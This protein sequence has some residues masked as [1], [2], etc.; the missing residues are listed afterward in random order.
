MGRILTMKAVFLIAASLLVV[1]YA[2]QPTADDV[3]P[4]AQLLAAKAQHHGHT[5]GSQVHKIDPVADDLAHC[6]SCKE[7][8]VLNMGHEYKACSEGH[9]DAHAFDEQHKKA[10]HEFHK[11]IADAK[12]LV[13]DQHDEIDHVESECLAITADLAS[14]HHDC[15]HGDCKPYSDFHA[16]VEQLKDKCV[17]RHDFS[18]LADDSNT[19]TEFLQRRN[20]GADPE[21][22][23]AGET[24]LMSSSL[25]GKCS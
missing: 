15:A 19:E 1:A 10:E 9:C 2:L 8:A 24:Q 5:K 22:Q 7:Q 16:H 21:S 18:Q 6:E 3:V 14:M 23:L 11:A 12:K 17:L 20:G 25:E 13:P 4:E